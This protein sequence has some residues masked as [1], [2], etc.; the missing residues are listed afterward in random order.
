M[1]EIKTKL[2]HLRQMVVGSFAVKMQK[3]GFDRHSGGSFFRKTDFGRL[4]ITLLFSNYHDSLKIE[5]SAFIKIDEVENLLFEYRTKV[6]V[7]GF[8]PKKPNDF[9]VC[10]NLGIL[11]T[12]VWRRWFI[13]DE[14]E[15]KATLY[16]IEVLVT[17]AGLPFLDRFQRPELLMREIVESTTRESVLG[18]PIFRSDHLFALTVALNRRD[19]FDEMRPVFEEKFRNH[20]QYRFENVVRY[21]DWIASKFPKV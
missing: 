12:G 10:E 15:I 13:R 1:E 9:T 19:V 5:A 3:Y 11:K 2:K 14:S 6:R 16:E 8:P 21:F 20:R 7:E 4:G 18:R 17:S